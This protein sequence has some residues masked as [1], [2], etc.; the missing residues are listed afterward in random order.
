MPFSLKDKV[1]AKVNELLEQDIIERVQR[2]TACVSPII[3]AP[4]ASRD[5]RLY[6]D[7]RRANEAI[8]HERYGPIPT[9]DE[10][11]KGVNRSAMFSE[12]DLR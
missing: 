4:K 2:S 1:T 7:L 8:I 3:V 11:L 9:K 5:I 6:A 10:V 12:L